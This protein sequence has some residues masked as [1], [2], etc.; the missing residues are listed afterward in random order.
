MSRANLSRLISP[1]SIA[2]VGNRGAD[3]AI[4]ESKKLGYSQKIWAI[5][6]TLN[7]LEGVK[8]YRNIKDLPE[9]PDATF[10]AVNAESAIDASNRPANCLYVYSWQP[11]KHK[12]CRYYSCDA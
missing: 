1:Q 2:V 5:H 12:Y 6:P 3:F 9:A 4:R 8:C 10:I 7:S 11:N